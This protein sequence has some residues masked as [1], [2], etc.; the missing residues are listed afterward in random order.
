MPPFLLT[1]AQRG[2]D[3][4]DAAHFD[5]VAVLIENKSHRVRI[6]AVEIEHPPVICRVLH[7]SDP[8]AW[9]E[10]VLR[11]EVAVRD[12]VQ[13]TGLYLVRDVVSER[14]VVAEIPLDR[15]GRRRAAS[16]RRGFCAD[17]DVAVDDD[18]L[19][20][21]DRRVDVLFS[22]RQCLVTEVH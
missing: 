11:A 9:L 21:Q 2:L 4:N 1:P 6:V 12:G 15:A 17:R 22:L 3:L 20:V 14:D 7:I 19:P 16:R 8:W 5:Y 10:T 13:Q 18:G